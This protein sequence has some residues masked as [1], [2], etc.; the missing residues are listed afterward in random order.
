[1]PARFKLSPSPPDSVAPATPEEWELWLSTRHS[2]SLGVWV[3]FE[4]KSKAFHHGHALDAALCYGWI[5]GQT[6]SLS[7]TQWMQRFL[8]RSRRSIWSKIN[9]AKALELIE[10]GRMKPAGRAQVES[11]QKDGRWQRAYDGPKDSRVPNDLAEALRLK[12]KAQAFFETLDGKNR[13]A[14]L[15]RLQTAKKP[16][17]RA[18]RLE[19]FVD[20]LEEG[21]TLH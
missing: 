3:V 18:R 20:M 17:T 8:P 15:F 21:R 10:S 1:M 12:P 5:D 6:R 13:Y 16:E 9:C 2:S 4:K 7:G 11:A 19:S 14:I